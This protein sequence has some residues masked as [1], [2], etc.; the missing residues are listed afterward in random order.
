MKEIKGEF[1][2]T[3]SEA[4]LATDIF[5]NTVS[6]LRTAQIVLLYSEGEARRNIKII[7]DELNPIGRSLLEEL[8][9]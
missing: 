7:F 9:R 6:T 4:P 3:S 5:G 1:Y 2:L 8:A